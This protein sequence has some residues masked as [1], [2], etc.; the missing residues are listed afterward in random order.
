MHIWTMENWKQIVPAER[1]APK[2]RASA[3]SDRGVDG[4]LRAACRAFVAW[5]R[6]TYIF[7]LPLRVYLR[8]QARIRAMDGDWVVGTFYEP[9][10]FAHTPYMRIA[11]GDYADLRKTRSRDD[12]IASILAVIAHETTH[13]S[14]GSTT[15]P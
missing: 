9:P 3:F 13:Y 6:E 1:V 2:S 7:P 10:D 11:T 8:N 15:C 5:M 14:S 12:A 4:D